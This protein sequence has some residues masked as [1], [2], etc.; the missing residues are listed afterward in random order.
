MSGLACWPSSEPIVEHREGRSLTRGHRPVERLRGGHLHRLDLGH[1]LALHVAGDGDAEAGDEG[2]DRADARGLAVHRDVVR[3]GH[4]GL[5]PVVGRLGSLARSASR[6]MRCSA[7]PMTTAAADHVGGEDD[8]REG[9]EL[10]LVGQDREEVGQLGAAGGLVVRV[11][12]RVLHERVG[13]EDEVGREHGADVDDPHRRGVQLLGDASPAED[14]QAEEGRLE[15]EGEQRL[16]RERRA[17]DV[18]DE[19]RVVGPVHPELELL[20]DAGHEPE[21]EVDE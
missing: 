20:H 3:L 10:D 8:V 13:R 6:R 2:D 9:D 15:E 16:D 17:E 4:T 14:P 11:A 18:T 7:T 12:D 21:G 5:R 1:D 19:A